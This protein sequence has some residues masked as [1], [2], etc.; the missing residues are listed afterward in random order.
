ML[1]TIEAHA[2]GNTRRL[3]AQPNAVSRRDV[4]GRNILLLLA[5]I[6]AC[7]RV[8]SSMTRSGCL[9]ISSAATL[10]TQKK[11]RAHPADQG[12]GARWRRVVRARRTATAGPCE[13]RSL[14]GKTERVTIDA[15]ACRAEHKSRLRTR[16]RVELLVA[17]E[18]MPRA[19]IRP[20][21][22]GARAPAE[23]RAGVGTSSHPTASA[24]RADQ[25]AVRS[26]C[27]FE[28]QA[29]IE[30]LLFYACAHRN[31]LGIQSTGAPHW[32]C[33]T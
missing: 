31:L 25:R 16:G 13:R 21:S 3:S 17:V 2:D 20:S 29:G 5:R 8:A 26:R 28:Q 15:T 27:S 9:L 4:E 32:A 12:G 6:M 22:R 1:D 19:A 14:A 10:R 7:T 30:T 24:G 23:D 18:L 33:G 11:T